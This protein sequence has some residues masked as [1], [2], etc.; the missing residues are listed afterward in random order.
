MMPRDRIADPLALE[1]VVWVLAEVRAS[2][3]VGVVGHPE[4][5]IVELSTRL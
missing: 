4:Q 2:Q 3:E 1:D 5:G